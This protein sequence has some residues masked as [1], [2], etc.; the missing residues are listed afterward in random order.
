MSYHL[1]GAKVGAGSVSGRVSPSCRDVRCLLLRPTSSECTSRSSQHG[2]YESLRDRQA[3]DLWRWARWP[4][5]RSGELH[6]ILGPGGVRPAWID[7]VGCCRRGSH[8]HATPRAVGLPIPRVRGTLLTPY[9]SHGRPA[10]VGATWTVLPCRRPAGSF[11]LPRAP[12]HALQLSTVHSV[13]LSCWM[14]PTLGLN[15]SKVTPGLLAGGSRGIL[16][17]MMA[18]R[19]MRHTR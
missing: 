6:M 15:D 4:A 19:R 12:S 8:A 1:P 2:L 10:R 7:P 11:L 14:L 18:G 9:G 3:P 13:R 16:S 17:S 5:E